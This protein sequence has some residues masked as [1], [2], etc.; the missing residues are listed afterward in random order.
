M[1]ATV[2]A[3]ETTDAAVHALWIGATVASLVA[4]YQGTV[5]LGLLSTAFWAARMRATGTML[6]ANAMGVCAALAAPMRF[7]GHAAPWRR[8]LPRQPSPCLRELRGDVAVGITDAALWNV[9]PSACGGVD[10]R[11]GANGGPRP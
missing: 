11:L 2:A 8:T 6:D 10:R 1:G 4:V 3:A 7:L 9:A 5:D